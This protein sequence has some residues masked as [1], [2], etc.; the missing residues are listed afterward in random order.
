[1]EL[2]K[3]DPAEYGLEENK[4]KQISDMFKPM[5][6]QMEDLETEF[7]AVV[8]MEINDDA[9]AAA[10]ELRLKYVKVRTGTAKIHKELK[11]FYLQ[12]GRFVDGW[13]NAQLMASQGNEEK[14]MA[15]EKHFENLERERI[16]KL[17]VERRELALKYVQSEQ[18]I[19]E[20]LGEMLDP[21]WENY[22][23]GL[24]ANYEARVAAEK[25]A[26]EERQELQRINELHDIRKANLINEDLWQF[27][28][29]WLESEHLGEI[30]EEKFEELKNDLI[31]KKE[32]DREEREK[33]RQEN[34]RLRKEAEEREKREAAEREKHE[35]E[36]A[37]A[38]AK[39]KEIEAQ[40]Q[41][42]REEKAKAE[43]EEQARV[44]AELKKGD[45][46]K[47]KD[48]VSD[49]E[50]LKNKYEFKSK[51]NQKLYLQVGELIDKTVTF[52]QTKN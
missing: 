26:E 42:E 33:Q 43:A 49:L 28:E 12:G 25:K 38:D 52:I 50:A 37:A 41:K 14:L 11:S 24:K 13:K 6:D 4:A 3:V 29:E 51:T 20:A 36:L 7:N 46:D 8:K 27:R 5:L 15:I 34:E 39:Q 48:L 32:A 23:D 9:V 1:M 17:N 16:E 2:V 19:P 21:V 30:G 22:L 35:A 31:A 18:L 10:K 40:L 44:E 47:I 45:A